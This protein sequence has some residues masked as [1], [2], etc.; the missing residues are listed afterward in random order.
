MRAPTVKKN[1]HFTFQAASSNL[2]DH[3]TLQT[4]K[5]FTHIDRWTK[6]KIP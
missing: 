4:I 6:Y 1:V 3:Q 2:I 5:T